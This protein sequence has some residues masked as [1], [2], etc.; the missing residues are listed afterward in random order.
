MR[1]ASADCE[2]ELCR[3]SNNQNGWTKPLCTLKRLTALYFLW[4]SMAKK[5][6]QR[7]TQEISKKKRAI[8]MLTAVVAKI[9]WSS[10]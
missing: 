3:C 10:R 7:K 4:L 1:V 2:A 8:I 6:T 9:I 5:K